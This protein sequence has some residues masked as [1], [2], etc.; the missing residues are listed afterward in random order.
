MRT[1]FISRQLE[2]GSDL[3]E[4]LQQAGYSIIDV[5]MITLQ[6]KEFSPTLPDTD[7]IFF[8]SKN[9][10]NFFFMQQPELENRKLAAIGAATAAALPPQ[11]SS[12]WT[13]NT[14]NIEEVGNQFASVIG[15]AKVLFPQSDQS[16]QTVQHCL[17][18]EQVENLICYTTAPQP[19]AVPAAHV[20][21]FTSPSNVKAY[22]VANMITHGQHLIAFGNSTAE[23]LRANGLE[24]VTTL[25]KLNATEL[26]NTI[27]ALEV[28]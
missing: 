5:P 20:L 3:R 10:V 22:L 21:V 9:A 12:A 23:S 18:P 14:N 26:V 15:N 25:K 11:Y 4:A 24:N 7:W 17:K 2:V 27:L 13:G 1:V 6:S 16:L 28:S 19:L 8:S